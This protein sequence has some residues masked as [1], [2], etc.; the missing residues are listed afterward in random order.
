LIFTYTIVTA[1]QK[2]RVRLESEPVTGWIDAEAVHFGRPHGVGIRFS[3]PCRPE[4][5]LA[6]T[7]G[8]NPRLA[9][10]SDEETPHIEEVRAI[11][12]APPAVPS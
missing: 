11:K 4:F 3:S 6:A 7:R 1:S 2:L 10:P 8:G 5:V 9:N 12:W